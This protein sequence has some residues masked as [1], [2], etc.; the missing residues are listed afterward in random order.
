VKLAF[1]PSLTQFRN[2]A[3]GPTGPTPVQ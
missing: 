1:L 3:P 2:F